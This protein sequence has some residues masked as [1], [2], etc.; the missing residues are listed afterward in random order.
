[1][2]LGLAYLTPPQAATARSGTDPDDNTAA[3]SAE[4]KATDLVARCIDGDDM[5]VV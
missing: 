5:D 1:M 3:A 4:A 2:C